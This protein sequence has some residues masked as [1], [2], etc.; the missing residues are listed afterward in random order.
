MIK[1]YFEH[2]A[3]ECGW[4]AVARDICYKDTDPA[5]VDNMEVKEVASNLAHGLIPRLDADPREPGH[6]LRENCLLYLV[7]NIELLVQDK[8]IMESTH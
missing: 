5:A 3:Y 8:Q 6:L 2:G 1:G 7:G 4:D